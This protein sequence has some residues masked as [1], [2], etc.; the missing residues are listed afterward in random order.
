MEESGLSLAGSRTRGR[1]VRRS[2]QLVG[3]GGDG[4]CVGR[5]ERR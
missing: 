5:L 1:E 4:D 2:R 3:D